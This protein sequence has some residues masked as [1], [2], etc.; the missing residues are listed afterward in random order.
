MIVEGRRNRDQ[1]AFV[2]EP[3]VDQAVG[4]EMFAPELR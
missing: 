4:E 2:I 3:V 1:I